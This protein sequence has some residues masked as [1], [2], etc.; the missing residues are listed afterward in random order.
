MAISYK[1][2]I[3]N[4]VSVASSVKETAV[5]P[6]ELALPD[7]QET[8]TLCT[9]GR[10]LIYS[11]YA[12]TNYSNIDLSKNITVDSAQL[13]LTQEENSQY[14]PFRMP[15]F[16]DGIDLMEM[17]IQIHY[18]NK[19]KKE[20][21][22]TPVNVAFNEQYIVFGWLI[23]GNVTS[24][25]G[26]IIFELVARGTNKMGDN[27]VWKTKP[28]GKINILAALSG[29]GIIQPSTDWYTS[30]VNTMNSKIQE[31][32]QY[33]DE[34]RASAELVDVDG[35]KESIKADL[36]PQMD[37]KIDAALTGYYTDAEID[38]FVSNLQTDLNSINSLNNL[39]VDYDNATGE[40]IFQDAAHDNAVLSR[41]TINS[42]SNLKVA[43]SVENGRGFL[44]FQN[45]D[46]LITKVEIGNVEPSA[47]WTAAFKVQ[48]ANDI[49]TSVDGVT[50]K[51][52]AAN[53]SIHETKDSVNAL[54]K[55]VTELKPKVEKLTTDISSTSSE[56]AKL[57]N[58]V[59]VI[60][61]DVSGYG[62]DIQSLNTGLSELEKTIGDIGKVESNTYDADYADNIFTLYENDEIKRQFT[63]T[64]GGGGSTDTSTVT[65]E[66]V[67]DSSAI[68]L[69]GQPAILEY[70]FSSVD[71][72][73]DDTGNG[74]AVW[75]LGNSIV[76]TSTAV[77]GK[78]AFD[79]T[80][81][82][83]TGAN[84]IRL[85]ITDSFGTVASKTW[86]ITIVEFKMESLFDD[87]LFYSDEVI[88]R[89]TPYGDIQKTVHFVL[90]GKEIAGVTTS[91]TGRQ[92]TQTIAPQAHG[93]HLLKVY[94]TATING[95]DVVS[96]PIQKDIIWVDPDSSIPI[97]GC[98]L[99][100][101][102]AKQYSSTTIPYVVYDPLNNPVPISLSV[103]GELVSS[104]SV[105][106][107]RHVWSYKSS[108]IGA[109]NLTITCGEVKKTIT[110][111]IED[112][113]IEIQPV[114]TN[115]AF[116]F[117]PAGRSNNDVNRLWT[118]G[119]TSL[120]VSDNFDWA[121]GGYQT[122][123]D[124]DTYFCVK[125]GSTAVIDYPLFADDAKKTGKNFKLIYKCANVRDYDAA[126][127]TC[128]DHGIGLSVN[129]QAS[130]L[131]SEQNSINVP[132]CEDNYMEL[133]CNILPDSQF[134]ETVKWIDGIPTQVVLYSP[135]DNFTQPSPK[136]I[137]IGSPDCDVWVY[138]MKSYTMNLTD[139]EILDNHIADA[140]N[141]EEII[142][143]HTRNQIIGAN[144][145][146]DP[147]L[148][149]ERYPD[150]RIIKLSAPR[151][152]TG[153]K[154]EIPAT[155]IQHILKGGRP[156]DNWTAT[157]SHKGQGTSSDNYG[158]AARNID[159]KCSGGFTF[160]DGT[161][162]SAYDMTENSVPVA[163]FN[164]KLNVASS[165][166]ANNAV[167]ADEYNTFN[168]YLRKSRLS[169]SRVR[170][171]MEFHPCVVFIQETD[172]DSSA[173]F[174]DGQ[175]HFYGCGDFG[176]SKKNS[177]AMGMDPENHK[178]FIVELGNNTD[179]QTRFLSDDLT[180]ETW[181]GDN[182]FEFRYVNPG[183]TEEEIQAGKDAWQRALSWVVNTTP[184]RFVSEFEEYFIKDSLLFFYLFTERHTMVDN[185]AKNVFF[186]TEDLIHWDCCFDYDNDTACGNDNEGGLTLTY[187]YEDTDTI[188]NKSVFNASDSK[189]WC[190]IR[191]YMFD[192]LQ[193]LF[194]RTE[195]AGAW[196]ASRFLKKVEDYQ[197]LKPERLVIAD[198]RRK[199]FRP[200]EQNGTTSY[201]PMMHGDK[202]H[203][204]RQFEKYQEKY[205][206]SKYMGAACTSDVITIRGY[207]PLN[208][209]GV[210]PDGT[211][212]VVPYA[213]TYIVTRYGSNVVKVRA[214]RGDLKIIES[215][216]H[217]M[218]D[219]EVYVYNA[220]LMRSI[221]ELSGFY[222][223]YTDFGQALKLTDLLVGSGV[224]GY[225]N[226]NMND[227]DIGNNTL[228]EKLDL[229]NLPNLRKTISLAGCANLTEFLADGSGITGV[230]FASG[231][232]IQTAHL[233]AVASLTAKNLNFLTDLRLEGYQNL[234]TLSID[235]SPAVDGKAILEKSPHVNRLRLTGITWELENT[236]LLDRLSS[237]TGI[238]EHGYNVEHSVLSG[239]V[240]VPVMRQKKLD[241]YMNLWPDL[242]ITYD[243]MITQYAVTF[244]NDNE[245]HTVLDVQYVDKGGNAVDPVTRDT[246]PIPIPTKESTISTD[247]TFSGWDDS[248]TLIFSDK[249]IIAVYTESLREYTVRYISKGLVLQESKAPYGTTVYY[250][251]DTP[252][253]T[254]EESA[255]KYNLFRRWDK[256][257][258]VDG[259]KDI[260]AVYDTCEYVN[261]YFDGKE[262]SQ[263]S[264]I[265]LY[266][267]MKLG[268][269]TD[270]LDIK[271][272]LDFKLG[273]DHSF[274]DIEE[275]E[276]I[277]SDM[278]FDGSRYYDTGIPVMD[279]DRGFTLAIDFEFAAGNT[280]GG[281]LAQCFQSDGSNG[282]RI[283]YGTEPRLSWGTDST[284]P[285]NGIN[286]EIVVLRHE[287]GSNKITVYN[288]N[289]SGDNVTTV[290]LT[291]LRNP[292]INSTLVFGCSKADD[293]IYENYAKG[294]VHWCKVWYA[295]LGADMCTDIARWIHE[296]IPM[297]LAKFKGYYL[298]DTASKRASMTFLAANILGVKKQ[299][300]TKSTNDGGWEKS[301]LNTWLNNRLIKAVSPLWRALIKPVKVSSSIGMKS[302]DTSQSSCHFFIP[303]LYEI[304]NSAATEP[305]INE[306][307]AAI[308]YM[309]NNESRKRTKVS[310]PDVY[311]SYWTRS[312]N[313][314]Y[315]NYIFNVGVEGDTNGFSYPSYED[316]VLLMFSIGV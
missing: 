42:L 87:A 137:T 24:V 277:A 135:G 212:R 82:L 10:Y 196:S 305:Y 111:S 91:V 248:F 210:Q 47:E 150:L 215:P 166:N 81:Y 39:K 158:E 54:S 184:E 40:L 257:G 297:E 229:R 164:I 299:F 140:K 306:T 38:A 95:Q 187:G 25:A 304:D 302:M 285:T 86:T 224:E 246:N 149:A 96:D 139:D 312:P 262:L 136:P 127:L 221:G 156:K 284:R 115:L 94:M 202:K 77:Q 114:T 85:T 247:Y 122:D 37:S 313:A 240:H 230:V 236:D 23:N 116:D 11:E 167:L 279:K 26:E 145:E 274:A 101:F 93:S 72:A 249:T 173:E 161:T 66:R 126:V 48:I 199:Y 290:E 51:I 254:A 238:D 80:S 52:D 207:T 226:T 120:T 168:P 14:I 231:G 110:A 50:E 234:T 6:A 146:I 258:L 121:N 61:T 266:T 89:Y 78:N 45:G 159:I 141:A 300:T 307:N 27:Y 32:K 314:T 69:M 49:K 294:T 148:L 71:N 200:Y 65:I 174:H 123:E 99:S 296:T 291:A 15:R 119:K 31:A 41:I 1:N 191:D 171:T 8:Y 252:V 132:Y 125:A 218:N 124:G 192:D 283:W 19:D 223:G 278:K 204:R 5:S 144:G 105:D 264:E 222:A 286:R 108:R 198:M 109:Q 228:L 216:V 190:Y 83:K 57:A 292:V 310:S 271:D 243:T 186:H 217:S 131:T 138:R 201:L 239:T 311:E 213:D 74:T 154:N 98:S 203:Q 3:Q 30:F 160:G 275:H 88:F 193:A 53:Q 270:L 178:E 232:K 128:L 209:S 170:D 281:T 163:Y 316:G 59:E 64:G 157:G 301:S 288:S 58:E 308:P 315:T 225:Q 180:A 251:G 169:D 67:T 70:T 197:A 205:I 282:F 16:W 20:D 181:D 112:I 175:W 118:D 261:G 100:S 155:T 7:T 102:T 233:P 133:E 68:F 176:N 185:R 21:F 142:R 117:N 28:N 97:I 92:M 195:G 177:E 241:D 43:Y 104:L 46:T 237:L 280:S 208:W 75:K 12:D 84:N 220:S 265:E 269:E 289:M 44:N 35:M 56:T 287:A 179:L 22:V 73:G 151:F 103:D 235:S 303:S 62:A 293:G 36:E 188:G 268:L 211:F 113:G 129:A 18:V 152:T 309:V 244:V 255:Y 76:A 153:K 183:C 272:T 250:E 253:Y 263:L 60:K 63:I 55:D 295:D 17:M 219:T 172:I 107:T 2:S 79:L 143:R 162:G 130:V 13:N 214:K 267:L 242:E 259:D 4:K 273:I 29:T 298:S 194:L 189:L 134:T 227:F 256:S 276:V 206:A 34:A 182:S 106:R 9:D 147:D 90:D 165:E 245:D 260:Q 33:A